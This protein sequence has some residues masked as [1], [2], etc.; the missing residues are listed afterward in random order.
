MDL[1]QE[2]A[3]CAH[4]PNRQTEHS[5]QVIEHL[6]APLLITV[7]DDF[8]IGVRAEHVPVSFQFALQFREVVD[9]AVEDHPDGF[10]LVRH[11]L[12][13]ARK[14]DDG[15]PAKTQAQAG[16]VNIVA[17]VVRPAM[18]DGPGHPLDVRRSDRGFGSPK[19]IL[20]A[21]AAH[22]TVASCVTCEFRAAIPV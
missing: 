10:F 9:F 3:A 15:E 5:V 22:K 1:A 4:I 11:G 8:G 20:S 21:N 13:T 12:V 6:L 16:P 2:P 18:D 14:V 19:V 17:L 7:D